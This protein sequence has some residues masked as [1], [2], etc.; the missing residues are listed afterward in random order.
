MVIVTHRSMTILNVDRIFVV[1][2]GYVVE[3]G[4]FDELTDG[5]ETQFKEMVEM[6]RF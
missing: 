2:Y 1:D 3:E 5:V 6:Q 4:S